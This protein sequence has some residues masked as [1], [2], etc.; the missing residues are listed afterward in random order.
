MKHKINLVIILLLLWQ[1]LAMVVNKDVI[2][3]YP[4]DVIKRMLEML[5]DPSFYQTILITLSHVCIV[6]FISV[7]IAYFLSY[8]GYKYQMVD[9]YISPLLSIL[10]AIPNISFIIIVMV[11]CESLQTVYI[12]LFLVV[13]P[14]LYNNLIQGFKSID[15]DLID[16]IRSY[17]L[18][19]F[20]KFFTIYFPLVKRSLLSALKSS[21]S[22]GVKVAVMAEIIAQLP[23]GVGRAIN[24]SRIQFD[25][26]GVFA[27]T[28]WLIV[29]ILVI[30]GLL[31]RFIHDE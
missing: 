12:V 17:R 25:M 7:V 18:P 31:R 16:V 23:Q 28:L 10:Q 26:V 14:L 21:L 27:W 6:V 11:W 8:L 15:Q 2:I 24:F 1:L 22:L 29:M 3:P 9:Q 5:G 13:F 30:E 19:F 20:Y 4:F